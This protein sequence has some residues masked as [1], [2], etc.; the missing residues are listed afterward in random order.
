MNIRIEKRV[1]F[2][3]KGIWGKCYKLTNY[4]ETTN[5]ITYQ[6][7]TYYDI[8][9][10][11]QIKLLEEGVDKSVNN[12]QPIQNLITRGEYRYVKTTDAMFDGK[13]YECVIQP[14]DIVQFMGEYWVAEKVDERSIYL[15]NKQTFY[16]IGMRKIFD[17]VITGEN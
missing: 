9:Y 15:P 2:G 3:F 10:D 11:V 14:N 1:P 12:T 5:S 4:N 7:A 17:E 16:Y 8:G 13:K 6:R